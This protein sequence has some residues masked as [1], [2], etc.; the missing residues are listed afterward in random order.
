M[1]QNVLGT[2][3]TSDLLQ[4][5]PQR[6]WCCWSGHA[7]LWAS[8]TCSCRQRCLQWSALPGCPLLGGSRPTQV[9]AQLDRVG[10]PWGTRRQQCKQNTLVNTCKPQSSVRC[11]SAH[12]DQ[13]HSY[14]LGGHL[15]QHSLLDRTWKVHKGNTP[16]KLDVISRAALRRSC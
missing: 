3:I 11:Q 13:Q 1:M 5:Q 7:A 12:G 15:Q 9:I 6:Q 4:Q 16:L 14:N 2:S 10:G 8:W